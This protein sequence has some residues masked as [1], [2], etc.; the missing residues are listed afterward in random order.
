MI[1]DPS[2]SRATSYIQT[3]GTV[4]ASMRIAGD[5]TANPDQWDDDVIGRTYGVHVFDSITDQPATT[6]AVGY[7]QQ[8]SAR[9][10]FAVGFGYYLQA[11]VSGDSEMIDAT[12]ANRATVIDIESDEPTLAP[13]PDVG[14][15]VAMALYDLIDPDN[16]NHDTLDGVSADPDPFAT[17]DGLTTDITAREFFDEFVDQGGDGAKLARNFIHHG[18]WPDDS[19]EP[20]D[21]SGEVAFVAQIP[22]VQHDLVLHLLNEDWYR[23]TVPQAV[24]G[25]NVDVSFDRFIY[26]T[27]VI[28]ELIDSGGTVIGTGTPAGPADPVRL[29]TAPSGA[30][31]TGWAKNK[32]TSAMM[33]TMDLLMSCSPKYGS[34][35]SVP[36]LYQPPLSKKFYFR[37]HSTNDIR[38]PMSDFAQFSSAFPHLWTAPCWQGIC[39]RFDAYLAWRRAFE[40]GLVRSE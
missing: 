32:A 20:N 31:A 12:S 1:Y 21:H 10:A 38:W 26:D 17:A 25:L 33:I 6:Y 9:N 23:I 30:A 35:F 15:W 36:P 13:A 22:F 11:A 34:R 3:T 4:G 39:G 37:S 14:G 18:L 19:F 8:T 16:E 40:G 2:S 27:D 29:V 28:L 5:A 7:D 24:S